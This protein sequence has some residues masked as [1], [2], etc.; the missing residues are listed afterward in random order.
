MDL[1]V[2]IF[3]RAT[4]TPSFIVIAL[5]VARIRSLGSGAD[6]PAPGDEK[7]PQISGLFNSTCVHVG[8]TSFLS[9]MYCLISFL[10]DP[11]PKRRPKI[12]IS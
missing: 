3:G 6:P 11:S 8:F 10:T 4:N 7:T 1:K 12:Q 2:K 9:Q 5:I